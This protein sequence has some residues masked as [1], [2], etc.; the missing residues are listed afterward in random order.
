MCS[1]NVHFHLYSLPIPVKIYVNYFLITLPYGVCDCK[2][3][4]K[5]CIYKK[6]QACVQ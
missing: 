5:N 4:I 3:F 2:V 1:N 6:S